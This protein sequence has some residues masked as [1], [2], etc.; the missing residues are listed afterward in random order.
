MAPGFFDVVKKTRDRE[1]SIQVAA[2]TATNLV[3]T[4]AFVAPFPCT[5]QSISIVPQAAITGAA[6][7]NFG[8]RCKNKGAAGSGTDVIATKTFALG[9]DGA[10]FDSVS[11]GTVSNKELATGDVVSFEKF[12]NGNGM[13]MPAVLVSIV[14]RVKGGRQ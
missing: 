7:D 6:T 4:P 8:V 9:T 10:A 5:I 3:E 12:E 13:N 14:Y 11:L 1:T 2:L